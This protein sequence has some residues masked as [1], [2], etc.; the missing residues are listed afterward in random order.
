MV[1]SNART[2]LYE[3]R[4]SK[5]P[6]GGEHA[7]DGVGDDAHWHD[8]DARTECRELVI[9]DGH[10]IRTYA[11]LRSSHQM[12]ATGTR[13][14]SEPGN[15]PTDVASTLVQ[16]PTRPTELSAIMSAPPTKE[17]Q[18]PCGGHHRMQA[19]NRD[20]HPVECSGREAQQKDDRQ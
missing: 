17:K 18:G 9:P 13:M 10:Q 14:R 2:T 15:Q 12:S 11:V 3:S 1:D 6:D 5:S 20:E 8:V 16:L 4:E 7:P 19:D